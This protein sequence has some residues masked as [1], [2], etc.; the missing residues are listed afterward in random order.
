MLIYLIKQKLP[1]GAMFATANHVTNTSHRTIRYVKF[2]TTSS[3]G[4]LIIAIRQKAI[5]LRLLHWFKRSG[6]IQYGHDVTKNI[7]PHKI[8]KLVYKT[9]ILHHITLRQLE[10]PLCERDI[11]QYIIWCTDGSRCCV[12]LQKMPL[13]DRNRVQMHTLRVWRSGITN[14]IVCFQKNKR[15]TTSYEYINV[16]KT[17]LR[18]ME[19]AAYCSYLEMELV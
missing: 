8:M 19:D 7:F 17:Y 9:V 14:C 16:M 12:N 10:K 2:H 13:R 15:I 6:E 1:I 18:E 5:K 3:N 4:S 11:V